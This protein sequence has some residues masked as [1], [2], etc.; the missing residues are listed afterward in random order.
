MLAGLSL[1]ALL[2][3]TRQVAVEELVE[4]GMDPEEASRAVTEEPAGSDTPAQDAGAVTDEPP[5]D[6]G[7]SSRS[8]LLQRIAAAKT[9]RPGLGTRP[10]GGS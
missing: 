2:S 4:S 5:P 3:A 8:V 10:E 9:I 6:E 1:P 7:H